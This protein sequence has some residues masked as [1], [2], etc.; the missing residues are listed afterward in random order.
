LSRLSVPRVRSFLDKL[1]DDGASSAMVRRIK[2]SFGT[3]LADAQ[4]R[5]N[6]ARNVVRE[7][8]IKRGR[9]GAQERGSKLKVGVDI[10]TPSEIKALLQSAQGRF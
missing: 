6:V 4:E 5:G 9:N 3:L 1:L 7:M 10:P 8:K 2:T